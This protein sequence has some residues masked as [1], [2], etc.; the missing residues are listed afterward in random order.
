MEYFKTI[1]IRV[2]AS[3][4]FIVLGLTFWIQPHNVWWGGIAIGLLL[5][6]FDIR[7][8]SKE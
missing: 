7:Y 3:T 2:L 1:M 8:V 4:I 6:G 5:S